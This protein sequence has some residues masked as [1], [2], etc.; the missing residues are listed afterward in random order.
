[1]KFIHLLK[2]IYFANEWSQRRREQATQ[3]EN[4][5]EE[6]ENSATNEREMASCKSFE[7]IFHPN[8]AHQPITTGFLD[9]HWLFAF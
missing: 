4:R 8:S 2:L 6:R 7:K 9:S 3:Q 1:M 5:R